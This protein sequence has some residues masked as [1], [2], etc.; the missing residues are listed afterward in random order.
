MGLENGTQVASLGSDLYSL[1]LLQLNLIPLYF[2]EEVTT[3][4]RPV[5]SA[6]VKVSLVTG[7]PGMSRLLTNA[8]LTPSS[9]MLHI[10]EP[11]NLGYR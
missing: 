8:S 4:P 1:N 7:A 2:R 10:L 5:L 6:W 11:S 3:L 9:Q